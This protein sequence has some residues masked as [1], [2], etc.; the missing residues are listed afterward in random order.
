MLVPP[1]PLKKEKEKMK[2][3]IIIRNK[4]RTSLFAEILKKTCNMF[5][6][7]LKLLDDV[8]WCHIFH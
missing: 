5:I 7:H 8:D 3:H 1:G 2:D 6:T 4:A